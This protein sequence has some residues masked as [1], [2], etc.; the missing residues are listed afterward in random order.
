MAMEK[1]QLRFNV[2]RREPELVGP[3]AP[4]PRETKRLSDLDDHETLRVQVKFAFFYRAGG[5]HDAA[6]VVRRALGEAL[7]PYYPLAGR[8]RE[9]EERKL[10][11]D[12]TGEGVLFVEA[13]ADVRLEELEE[14]GDG[15][16][17]LRPPFPSMDQLLLDVEGSG[18]GVLGSPLLL[19]QVTRLLCGGFVLAVRVNHT[20]CDAIGAAQFLL[21]VG[22]LARG[23]PAPTVR[24]AWCRELLD[25]R[26]PPAPSFPHREFDVV[27]PPPPPGD[28]VTRTFT[29][30]AAD[31]AAIRE[32]LPPRLRGTATTFEA[33]TAFLWRARTAALELP[34][35][36]DA[37]LVVI[38]NLRGVAEL[39][40]PG[41]YY[42]N[43]CVAPTA[44]TTGEALLRRGSLG[45][46]AEMVR[47]A[48]AAVTA[49]YARSAA[50]MLVLRGR[51]LLA[52]SNVFV[53]SDHRH[54]GFHRLDLGW[55]EPAYGGGADVVFGL[56]FLVAVK[57]GG[58]GGESAVGALVSL[59]PPAM[60]RFA[61]EM[62]KLYTRPN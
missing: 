56:A 59:P 40:L 58:G 8:V 1:Q 3:A 61:S 22:E 13:D 55:G 17:E 52:L 26:S 57:N 28:L 37:R 9:V 45:D 41:G 7:V 23:L 53:V 25:A 27:P 29:F 38:A 62:E 33:L 42:G 21:A 16:G 50:D 32:G 35:G 20:M 11:V 2:R 60:E 39:N 12:C 5:E 6:G 4:T 19:V 24:P 43:A 18:G 51:P 15:G 49:E 47:E 48:K 36:E 44:I 31:V 30:T 14:D 46:A 54:A 10:V 34:D